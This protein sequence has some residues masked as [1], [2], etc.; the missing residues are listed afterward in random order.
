MTARRLRPINRRF[1]WVRPPIL[2]FTDSRSLRVL[3]ARG[4]IAYSLVTQP[5]PEPFRQRGTPTVTLAATSTRVWPYSTRT[6]PS[7]WL[8][9]LRVKRTSRSWSRSRPSAREV[10]KSTLGAAMT[11]QSPW[12]DGPAGPGDRQRDRAVEVRDRLGEHL[13]R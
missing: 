7:A 4:S 9:Q 13:V 2:P 11:G 5:S 8:S 3:V 10:M 12:T 1:W 6:E